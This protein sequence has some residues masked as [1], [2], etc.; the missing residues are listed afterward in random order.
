MRRIINKIILKFNF[1]ADKEQKF[2]R[3]CQWLP[4]EKLKN[5]QLKR[6][7]HLLNYS[8]NYVP[9]YKKLFEDFG[10]IKKTGI[11]IEKFYKLPLLDKVKIRENYDSL[12]SI[13]IKNLNAS[14]NRTGGATGEPLEFYQDRRSA[15]IT[16]GVVLRWFYEWHGIGSG[17]KELKL[18]GSTR[19]L[20]YKS[21]INM[22][23]VRE[24][25]SG[26]KVLNA[27]K[28]TP[29]TMRNYV[30]IINKF[31]PKLIRGYTSNL[32]E[33]ANYILENNLTVF[34]PKVIIS[35][36]ETLHDFIRE[37]IEKAF[38][39]KVYN[40]YGSREMH[41]MAMEC[42]FGGLHISILTHYYEIL[43]DNGEP[44]PPGVEGNLVITNLFN[45]AMPFIRYKIGDRA[46]FSEKKCKCGRGLPLLE[47]LN[48]RIVES[49]RTKDGKIIPGTYFIH[50]IGVCLNSN[51]IEK[52]Q[53]VQE[54]YDKILF[55]I[56]LKKGKIFDNKLKEEIIDK[57]KLLV[58]NN[59]EINF[60]FL[61]D[62]PLTE[63][64]KYIFTICK[65]M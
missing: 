62:I 50:L 45:K 14:T 58:G 1:D 26:I 53:V 61:D 6:L 25:I 57:T 33:L 15:M 41:N 43:D 27:F 29:E 46:A 52:F 54:D 16:G 28:M 39:C 9:Y 24:W 55:K 11:N 20:F 7:E 22:N 21:K 36:A 37:K 42:P 49:F 34:S 31:K 13:N 19:D 60:E 23:M 48:G 65:V 56:C 35:S 2:L 4:T 63:N 51:P 32:Y 64:G 38:G 12:K 8:Y 44:C 47:K 5:I 17:D 10:L 3:E 40:H 59:C 18:W 30:K